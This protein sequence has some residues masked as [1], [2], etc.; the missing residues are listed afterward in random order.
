MLDPWLYCQ[1]KEINAQNYQLQMPFVAISTEEFHP[2]CENW[3]E[4]FR[5]I[6]SLLDNAQDPRQ[7]HI[8]V[9]KTGHI[10]QV[11]FSVVSPLELFCITRSRPQLTTV[12][13]Y[14]LMSKLWLSFTERSGLSD[15]TLK[16]EDVGQ[17]LSGM[18]DE[19]LHYDQKYEEG[20]VFDSA[21]YNPYV[22]PEVKIQNPFAKPI[23]NR[24]KQYSSFEISDGL[25]K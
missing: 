3:F 21:N 18:H 2:F 9:K 7:E 19:W 11:D 1:H 16:F 24:Q 13:T 10:H 14:L 15:P 20:K 8:I 6:R 5:T 22:F 4:S 12:Q 17:A 25:M 23:K